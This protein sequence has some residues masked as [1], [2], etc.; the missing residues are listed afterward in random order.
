MIKAIMHFNKHRLNGHSL[1]FTILLSA[2]CSLLSAQTITDVWGGARSC[3]ALCSD[4]TVW[5]W[6]GNRV[7]T[8]MMGLLGNNDTTM[9][10]SRFPVQVAG[11]GGV[12]FLHSIK[13]IG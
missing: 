2:G 7:A 1:I 10:E 3:I 5:C 11:P 8:I 4:S 6:G 12:G 13:A 9:T